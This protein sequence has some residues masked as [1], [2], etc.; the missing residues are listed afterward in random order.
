[1]TITEDV[2]PEISGH[3]A[4]R[5]HK[6]KLVATDDRQF[7]C[8]GCMERGVGTRY[9]CEYERCNFDL[10]T[11]C[12]VA[13]ATLKHPLFGDRAFVFLLE[14]PATTGGKGEGRSRRRSRVCDACG[15]DVRGFVY[16]CFEADLDLHPCCAHLQELML[17]DGQV[18][19]LRREASRPCGM[20]GRNGRRSNFWAY[21][22]S[23]EGEAVDLHVACMTEMARLS[24]DAEYQNRVGGGQIVQPRGLTADDM[25]KSLPSRTRR[26][27]GFQQF[28]RIVSVV[29]S[30]IVAVIF[31]NPM[32]MIAA[33]AGPGGFLR[34]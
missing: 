15:E 28:C 31:G 6:L 23:W 14:P 18:L 4:H 34:G 2:P 8:D 21:R 19:K 3:P 20:C 27:S 1:M 22:I 11:C 26:S 7:R 17:Q 25:L 13:P 9:R 16:H 12:A 30:V 5:A 24:W 33:V 29:L 32:A 10:H